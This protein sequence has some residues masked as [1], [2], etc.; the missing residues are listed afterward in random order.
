MYVHL[1]S[2][3][4]FPMFK[5]VHHDLITARQLQNSVFHTV[6]GRFVVPGEA[7]RS[8]T[9]ALE[10]RFSSNQVTTRVSSL[11]MFC[12]TGLYGTCRL[13]LVRMK[14]LI[15]LETPISRGTAW[16]SQSSKVTV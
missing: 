16:R 5:Y 11:Y 3:I 6:L 8:L 2:Q 15:V 10:N 9:G 14:R 1:A 7:I 12:D 4:L 13:A